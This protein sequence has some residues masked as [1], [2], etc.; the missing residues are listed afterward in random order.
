MKKNSSG[1]FLAAAMSDIIESENHQNLF[2]PLK[3]KQASIELNPVQKALGNLIAASEILERLKLNESAFECVKLANGISDFIL[4][5][6]SEEEPEDLLP[7]SYKSN[8]D[9]F[10]D[11]EL[12]ELLE[13]EFEEEEDE[14]P[15]SLFGRIK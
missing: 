1:D 2:Q 9:P 13:E 3:I 11:P 12:E 4:D 7:D 15:G 10:M 14:E 6:E 5:E 8:F